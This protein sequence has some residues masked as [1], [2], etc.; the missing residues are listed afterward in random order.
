MIFNKIILLPFFIIFA[1]DCSSFAQDVKIFL[2]EDFKNLDNWRPLHF[3]K[4]KEHSK[5]T[6]E[7]R[8]EDTYLRAESSASA[9]GIVFNK[10]FNVYEYPMALW[11]WKISNVFQKGNARRKSGDDYPI[12]IYIIFKYDHETASLG[13]KIKYGLA[14]KVYGEYPPDSSLNYIWANRKHGMHIMPNT[15]AKEARM[16]ILQTGTENAGKWIEQKV[17]IIEDYRKAFGAD[18]PDT[19]SL[20]IMNDSDNTGESAVSYIDYIEV[21]KK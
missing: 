15:Y 14:K 11:K 5:Y 4:I 13:K 21:F 16:I 10:E 18:P 12:R 17:N 1:I 8:Y 9:S 19:A 3:P 7:T 2:R 20:A 6:V